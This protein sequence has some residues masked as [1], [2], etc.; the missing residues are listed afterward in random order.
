MECVNPSRTQH[1]MI[2]CLLAGRSGRVGELVPFVHQISG[3]FLL[4]IP[5]SVQ[6]VSAQERHSLLG[7]FL[8]EFVVI[9]GCFE[10]EIISFLLIT[11]PFLKV[12]PNDPISGSFRSLS[13]PLDDVIATA[14]HVERGNFGIYFPAI[15][16]L[17][18]F[19]TGAFKY[20]TAKESFQLSTDLLW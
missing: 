10:E 20:H 16:N 15:L 5:Y 4:H 13:D 3:E 7:I 12:D 11:P 2:S 19:R 14:W 17:R 6:I 8:H 1:H 9:L 18:K